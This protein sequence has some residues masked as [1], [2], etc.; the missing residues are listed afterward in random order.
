MIVHYD[1]E[2]TLDYRHASARGLVH[3]LHLSPIRDRV[4]VLREF[5]IRTDPPG[6]LSEFVDPFRNVGHYL[7]RAGPLERLLITARSRVEVGPRPPAPQRLGGNAWEELRRAARSPELWLMSHPSRFVTFSP[8]LESFV[9]EHSLQPAEDPLA[10]A[11]ALCGRLFEIF[12]Y[13]PGSTAVDSPIEDILTSRRG[14]CQDYAHVMASILRLWGV[15]CR[16]VSG[17]LGP[18]ESDERRGTSHAWVE[19][20]F[21]EIGWT[22]F[23]PT[24]ATQVDESHVRVAVGRDYADV[25]PARG[26][27]WGAPESTLTTFEVISRR[28][29]G[30]APKAKSST[31]D[32]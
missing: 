7:D 31:T 6:P 21:P 9:R 22:G 19:C 1:I 12:E 16:Y 28:P 3:R 14:V 27:R 5:E 26:V 2:H 23:D 8:L 10:T 24:N 18:S 4:Q 13:L 29:S 32:S 17:Y 20:W 11:H 30:A 25:P 15:P